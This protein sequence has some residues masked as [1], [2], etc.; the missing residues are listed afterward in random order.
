MIVFDHKSDFLGIFLMV[1]CV[2]LVCLWDKARII[3]LS[4]IRDA[5]RNFFQGGEILTQSL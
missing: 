1:A 4:A 3:I 5:Y 2:I